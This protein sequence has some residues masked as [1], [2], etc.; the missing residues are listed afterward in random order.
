[1]STAGESGGGH[2]DA[3]GAARDEVLAR[4]RTATA[5]GTDPPPVA[6]RYRTAD[7]PPGLA[8]EEL[9]ELLVDRL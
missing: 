4:I 6:R 7:H 1:M 2:R 3:P 9:L 5:G 8:G